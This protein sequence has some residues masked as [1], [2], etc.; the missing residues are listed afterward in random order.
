M[1]A[2]IRSIGIY[3]PER[4]MPNEA[5]TKFLDTSD[6]WITSNTGIKNRYIAD[7]E[8]AASDLG[9]EAAKQALEK[10][11]ISAL[12]VDLV[13]V[14]T[15][16][17]DYRGFPSTA[18]IIQDRLG[19]T[20]AGA[21]DISAACTGFVYALE[22][23]RNYIVSNAAEK[24]LV[25]GTEIYSRVLDWTDRSTCVLFGDGAGAAFISNGSAER[26]ILDSVLGSDGSRADVL[27]IPGGSRVSS[28]PMEANGEYYLTMRGRP[29]YNFA[30]RVIT[31]VVSLLLERNK[32]TFDDL[33]YI[34]PHQAN[35]RIIQSAARRLKIPVEKFFTNIADVANTSAASI[36]LALRDMV[37][38]GRLKRDDLI[39]TVGFGGGLTYGGNLIRW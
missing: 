35:I 4:R 23:A 18:C 17:P 12:E 24:V 21:F 9:Y 15:A 7:D 39:V 8:Q 30:V 33:A 28:E 31:E 25:I 19:A 34:V 6:E 14:A 37:E 32:L 13:L 10:A 38:D 5:F 2:Q 27:K 36:P 26:G 20:G 29:V 11:E 22:T 1:K 16:T 3:L